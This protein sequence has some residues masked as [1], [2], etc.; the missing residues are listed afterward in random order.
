MKQFLVS[1]WFLI[2]LV[3]V[4]LVGFTQSER[5]AFLAKSKSNSISVA[6]QA[7]VALVLFWMALPLKF[8]A[9]LEAVRKPGAAILASVINL[10]LLPLVA[11]GMYFALQPVLQADLAIGILIA[12]A[13][14]STLASSAV[15]TRRA[16]GND[17]VANLVTV[18]TNLSC[19]LITPMWLVAMTGQ[20]VQSV[21]LSS[22]VLKLLYTVLLPMLAAQALRIIE[23]IGSWATRNKIPLGV[24]A[25]CGVLTMV[26]FGA[27][28][29]GLSLAAH[30]ERPATVGVDLLIMIGVVLTLHLLMLWLGHVFSKWMGLA[31]PERIAV[32]FAGS[33]KTLMV[34]LAIAIE[35]YGT[36]ALAVLPMIAYHV[37]QLLV[38]TAV[39]DRMRRTSDRTERPPG[40]A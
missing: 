3:L 5:L 30:R 22:M 8:G 34:G 14:P 16:G 39:A 29:G 37:G 18:I 6:R 10:G 26:L 27:V 12:A 19:F 40:S 23:P 17:M 4:L 21:E 38:D 20:K 1:R 25:Q 24:A 13:T 9:V 2:A 35:D 28:S 7:I 32:G 31:R 33:Q 36:L 11:W 15:W